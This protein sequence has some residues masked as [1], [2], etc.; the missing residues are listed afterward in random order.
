MN[1]LKTIFTLGIMFLFVN[2]SYSQEK[3]VVLN[4]KSIHMEWDGKPKDIPDWANRNSS[5]TF[6]GGNVTFEMDGIPSLYR[7]T[8]TPSKRLKTPDGITYVQSEYLN[9]INK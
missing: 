9:E 3:K 5:M 8:N 1:F 7:R 6:E 2:Y 4:F